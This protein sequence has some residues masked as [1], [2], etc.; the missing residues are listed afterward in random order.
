MRDIAVCISNDNR[1]VNPIETIDFV[2][3]AGFKNVFI[4]L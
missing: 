3:E 1:N 4:Q 2:K